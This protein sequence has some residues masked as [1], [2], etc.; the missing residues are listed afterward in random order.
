MLAC[1]KGDMDDMFEDNFERRV[2][3]TYWADHMII[4][5]FETYVLQLNTLNTAKDS[6][7]SQQDETSFEALRSAWLE[8]YLA[9]QKVSMFDIGKAEEITLRNF[10][11]IYPTDTAG[12][13]DN[14]ASHSYNLALPS[15]FDAQGFPA[16]DYLLYGT[17]D[18]DP[19]IRILL[20]SDAYSVYLDDLVRRLADLGTQVLEDWQGGFREQFINNSGSSA[21]AS[22]D[23]L[24]NDYIYYYEKFLRA[25]KVGIPAGVFS[26]TKLSGLVEAPYSGQY[27]RGLFLVAFAAVR[28]F[29]DGRN[30]DGTMTGESLSS[31]FAYVAEQNSTTDVSADLR[32]Q[33]QLAEDKAE[34]LLPDFKEQVETDN[35]KM[36]ELYDELQRAVV[37]LKV[38]MLHALN[39]QV[40]YV[41][42]DGD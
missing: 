3:L 34:L 33:W 19:E 32:A 29:F 38:D 6:F 12:I 10:T 39:I 4:P 21:T 37:F 30:F 24:V 1:D 28:D 15:N 9:W 36:L 20:A 40:D 18:S 13:Q 35:I 17:A 8:A 2:M 42:A 26:G 7:L 14:I 23:K 11:N 16:L 22:T 5:A 31:Y 27:S 25:G 41:D